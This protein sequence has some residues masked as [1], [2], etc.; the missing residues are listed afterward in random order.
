MD[1]GAPLLLWY[2]AMSLWRGPKLRSPLR[3]GRCAL[4]A[5]FHGK[6]LTRW[7]Q[8]CILLAGLSLAWLWAAAK[9]TSATREPLLV[10]LPASQPLV[11]VVLPVTGARSADKLHNT[12]SQLDSDYG[13]WLHFVFAVESEDDP[14]VR[15]TRRHACWRPYAAPP[16]CRSTAT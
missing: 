9:R 10:A 14:A 15:T 4:L 12:R 2:S 1:R 6:A 7:R 16:S 3:S 11:T 5:R 13:G 8:S